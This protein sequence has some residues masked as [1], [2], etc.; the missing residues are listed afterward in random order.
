MALQAGPTAEAA[1]QEALA[2]HAIA[3]AD[4]DA[5]QRL[6]LDLAKSQNSADLP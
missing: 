6:V 1:F 3:A 4:M 2:S 5:V